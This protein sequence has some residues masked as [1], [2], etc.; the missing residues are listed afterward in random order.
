MDS[1]DSIK[2]VYRNSSDSTIITYNKNDNDTKN[3]TERTDD[4]STITNALLREHEIKK[5]T[6]FNYYVFFILLLVIVTILVIVIVLF[7]T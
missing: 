7:Y 2:T 6:I 4:I 5:K 3:D 1:V